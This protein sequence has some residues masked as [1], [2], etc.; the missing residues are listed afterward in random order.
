MFFWKK[1]KEKSFE[2][3]FGELETTVL[4]EK[5]YKDARKVEQYVVERLEQ[6]IEL[7]KEIEDEKSEYRMVTSYLNDIQLLEEL[8]EEEHKKIE[9]IAV[10]VVQLNAAR[11]EFLNSAK[12]LSDAQFAQLEQQEAEIPA[13]IQR[14]SANEVYRDTLKKD[15]K[16]LERE[17]SEWVLC[18]EYLAHQMSRLRYLLYIMV[19]VAATAAV[20]MGL[21]QVILEMD[22]FYGWMAW[23]FATALVICV[24]YLR[25]QSDSEEIAQAERCRNRAILLLNKVKIKYVNI[26]NAVDYAHEKY[27][28]ESATELNQQWEYYLEAVKEREKYQRTN[29]DLE[30]FKG[31]LVRMLSQYK[32]Y[33]AQ[34]WVTQALALVDP[35]EMVEVKHG[36]INRRQKL[37]ARIEYNMNIVKEQKAEAEQLLDKV[38]DMRPQ[39]EQI[40]FAI[41]RLSE[42]R[43]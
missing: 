2:K 36:L 9:E 13:A 5:D 12:K 1:K 17:K 38:G 29:E 14:L 33:D 19:G 43:S 42:N 39:V 15:M 37:R 20:V 40:L 11:T 3:K 25:I 4:S 34:V 28:V 31:R 10:N 6:M 35:K 26:E 23:I 32:F 16:Y 18:K 21:L 24:I 7:T 8:P 30:Y 27:H 22:M 41:D